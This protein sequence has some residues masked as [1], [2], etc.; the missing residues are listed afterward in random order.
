MIRIKMHIFK[1]K[2]PFHPPC[3]VKCG[4]QN[5]MLTVVQRAIGCWVLCVVV[6]WCGVD[7]VVVVTRCGYEV[8]MDCWVFTGGLFHFENMLGMFVYVFCSESW[9]IFV[10][11]VRMCWILMGFRLELDWLVW[12][13]V[14]GSGGGLMVIGLFLLCVC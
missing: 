5:G 12:A 8:W 2:L 4:L 6:W 9:I 1:V 14:V 7:L 3:E 11:W 13:S 10:F